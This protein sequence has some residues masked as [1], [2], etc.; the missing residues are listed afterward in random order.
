MSRTLTVLV[1][2][3]KKYTLAAEERPCYET[4]LQ[5]LGEMWEKKS[6]ENNFHSPTNSFCMLTILST[7]Q[8]L[9]WGRFPPPPTLFWKGN[10]SRFLRQGKGGE[11]TPG[12]GKRQGPRK[13]RRQKRKIKTLILDRFSPQEP[14]LE[15]QKLVT[16][17]EPR[18]LFLR[19][20]KASL[21]STGISSFLASKLHIS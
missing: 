14:T 20:I 13:E 5:G 10:T 9:N 16:G 11:K 12:A 1:F 6:R 21:V 7:S 2:C 19:D 8:S 15:G 17:G 4:V 3:V 18:K